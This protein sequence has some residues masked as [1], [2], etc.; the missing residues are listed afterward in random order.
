MQRLLI[1]GYGDIA[2]RFAS[3]LPDGVEPRPLTRSLGADLDR[4]DTLAAFRDWADTVLHTAPPGAA[5]DSDTRTANLLGLLGQGKRPARIVYLSTSGVYGD[6]RGERVDETR[7]VNPSTPRA[8]RRVDAEARLAAWCG[9]HDVALVILRVPG[10]YAA[11]RLP[12]ERLRAGTPALHAA[13]DGYT[14]H[15]HAD[16]LAEIALRACAPDAP[17]GIYNAAD[18]SEMRMGD[19]FDLVADRHD[20]P[21]PPRIARSETQGRISPEM[22]SFMGESRRLV[23]AKMKRELG[24]RLAYPTVFDG[25]P[26]QGALA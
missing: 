24:I 25:V 1:V 10:I 6:C 18:D 16:D 12:L 2:R 17:P 7:P 13:E 4:P 23:N 14:N 9:M 26:R 8:R 3:R 20:L 21:R 15:I 22:L 19:W 5:Q 11:D